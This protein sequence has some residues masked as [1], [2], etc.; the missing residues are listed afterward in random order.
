M[1]SFQKFG[2]QQLPPK[3]SFYSILT[4]EG[5]SD[6]Q[7]GHA[8]EAWKV[9]NINT[10]GMYHDL[11]LKSDIL[12]LVDV[13]SRTLEGLTSSTINL[14]HVIILRCQAWN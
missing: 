11:Y 9:F 4:D 2:D 5:I 10:M 3:D 1:H 6:E 14:I 7:Y 12:L 13:Y 8:L